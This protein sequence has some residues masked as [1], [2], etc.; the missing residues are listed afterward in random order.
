MTV[1]NTR[2]FFSHLL[3]NRPIPSSNF[4]LYDIKLNA[5][6]LINFGVLYGPDLLRK[7]DDF[8]LNHAFL[9][10]PCCL[11]HLAAYSGKVH[12]IRTGMTQ[13]EEMGILKEPTASSIVNVAVFSGIASTWKEDGAT[14]TSQ[15][16]NVKMVAK[17]FSKEKAF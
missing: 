15:F 12:K 4:S 3:M 16:A 1:A 14:V 17:Q 6:N 11:G 10:M 5:P 7:A 2:P 8:N 13:A 9:H